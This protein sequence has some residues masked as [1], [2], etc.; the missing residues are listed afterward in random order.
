MTVQIIVI[1]FIVALLGY[2]IYLHIRLAKKNLFIESTIRK[3]ASN[4]KSLSKEEIARLFH[5][6]KNTSFPGSLFNDRLFDEKPLNF[7][8]GNVRDSKIYIHYTKEETDAGNIIRDGF[9]F[10]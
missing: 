4:K 3:L 6:I 2:I 8:F 7:L 9:M 1:L 5:G 10:A